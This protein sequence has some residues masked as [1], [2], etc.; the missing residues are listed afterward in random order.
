[1]NLTAPARFSAVVQDHP[2][3]CRRAAKR[4]RPQQSTHHARED[5]AVWS[6]VEVRGPFSLARSWGRV[7]S[8]WVTRAGL[9]RAGLLDLRSVSA[10]A[11]LQRK[12]AAI[13]TCPQCGASETHRSQRHGK[14][15]D[16]LSYV[17][18][19]PVRCRVCQYRFRARWSEGQEKPGRPATVRQ[20]WIGGVV[21]AVGA[22]LVL[23]IGAGML[24]LALS[25]PP[26]V[27]RLESPSPGSTGRS[28]R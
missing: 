19:Y 2:A 25:G 18:W 3:S 12:G 16:L 6:L 22:G 5:A 14:L 20:G 15:D 26:D 10:R 17:G 28:K 24:V 9:N 23:V 27:P 7:V 21:L 4:L 13:L 8:V 11:R 1:M